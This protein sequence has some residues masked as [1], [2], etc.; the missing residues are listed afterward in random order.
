VFQ[1]RGGWI[2]LARTQPTNFP[3]YIRPIAAAAAVLLIYFTLRVPIA[4]CPEGPAIPA[5]VH[6]PLAS[7]VSL[8]CA[9]SLREQLLRGGRFSSCFARREGDSKKYYFFKSSCRRTKYL[10]FYKTFNKLKVR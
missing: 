4:K 1:P 2:A 5:Q 10:V 6:A 3:L 7:V 8:C 9:R